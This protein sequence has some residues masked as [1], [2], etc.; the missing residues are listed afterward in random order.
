MRVIGTVG[1]PGSGKGE[2]ATVARDKEIPVVVMGDVIRDVCRDRGLDPAEHHGQVAQQLREDEGQAAVAKRSLPQVRDSLDTADI[3][4]IDGLRS[5]TEVEAFNSAFGEEFLLVSIEAPF[6]LRAERLADRGRDASDT[7]LETLRT[8]D[9]R[10]LALGIGDVMQSAELTVDNSGG[11]ESFHASVN[12]LFEEGASAA[13]DGVI[14]PSQSEFTDGSES[15][16]DDS[17]ETT[18]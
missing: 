11:I 1:L 3:T 15:P 18:L 9:E 7:D 5:P 12:R 16:E 8:R 17:G 6:E 4:L 10:E 13:V 2:A 14:R